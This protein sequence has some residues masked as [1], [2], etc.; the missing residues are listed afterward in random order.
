MEIIF[1]YVGTTGAW[2]VALAALVACAG[3]NNEPPRQPETTLRMEEWT[4]TQ[5]PEPFSDD[6][7]Q[8][9]VAMPDY[10]QPKVPLL[11]R[12]MRRNPDQTIESAC[13]RDVGLEFDVDRNGKPIDITVTNSSGSTELDEFAIATV[14]NWKYAKHKDG[15]PEDFRKDL[16]ATISYLGPEGCD[17]KQ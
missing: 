11:I 1:K 6:P 3:K 13:T 5:K 15:E 16:A 2:V 7:G 14:S 10:A 12:V 4:E 8:V 9:A 17:E